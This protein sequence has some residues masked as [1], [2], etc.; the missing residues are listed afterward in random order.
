MKK[1]LK[2]IIL[3]LFAALIVLTFVSRTLYHRN[4]PQVSAVAIVPNIVPT[5]TITDTPIIVNGAWRVTEIPVTQGQQITRG[6]VL[7]TFDTRAFD[8][9]RRA[10]ELEIRRLEAEVEAEFENGDPL[11]ADALAL[12][13]ERLVYFLSFTPPENITAPVAGNITHVNAARGQLTASGV[14]LMVIQNVTEISGNPEPHVVP[15]NA[16]F[17]AQE[18]GGHYVYLLGRRRGILGMEDY[19][20]IVTVNLIRD[21]GILA[22]IIFPPHAIPPEEMNNLRVAVNFD[23]WINH[24]DTVWIRER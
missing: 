22:V 24:G 6:D 5:I 16:V 20:Q 3:V 10:L 12:A 23:T 4:L 19:V 15:S 14:P 1:L 17:Y 2:I 13:N 9:E 11:T 8:L 21:N 7:M 18:H